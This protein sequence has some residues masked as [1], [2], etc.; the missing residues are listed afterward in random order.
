MKSVFEFDTD[1]GIGKPTFDFEQDELIYAMLQCPLD[2]RGYLGSMEGNQAIIKK[3]Q[4][5]QYSK[6]I[7]RWFNSNPLAITNNYELRSIPVLGDLIESSKEVVITFNPICTG[8]LN[9]LVG[10]YSQY[11]DRHTYLDKIKVKSKYTARMLKYLIDNGFVRNIQMDLGELSDVLK[12]RKTSYPSLR[13]IEAKIIGN[14]VKQFD[15]LGIK[16]KFVRMP[17]GY[18]RCG[19]MTFDYRGFYEHFQID[20]KEVV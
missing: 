4:R 19:V 10:S 20:D 7:V 8:F 3:G 14:I 17:S 2:I 6:T 1:E 16:F 15:E 12:V 5:R 9:K 13:I 11:R 18:S